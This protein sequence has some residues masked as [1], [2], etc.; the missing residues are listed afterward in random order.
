MS[1]ILWVL[2]GGSVG[3]VFLMLLFYV[4]ERRGVRFLDSLRNRLDRATDWT[5][6]RWHTLMLYLGGGAGRVGFHY[7]MHHLLGFARGVARQLEQQLVRLQRRNK[8]VVRSVQAARTE[9]HL[10]AIAEHKHATALSED[11]KKDLKE[12]S[13]EG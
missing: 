3:S 12:R 1:S 10:T 13:L 5:I 11:E 2:V 6:V 9:S 8:R 4:E 7:A